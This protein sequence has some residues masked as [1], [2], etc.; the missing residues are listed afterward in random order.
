[1]VPPVHMARRNVD[2][3]AKATETTELE[4]WGGGV[5][6]QGLRPHKA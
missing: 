3:S 6:A 4:K 5:E 1:V 2:S